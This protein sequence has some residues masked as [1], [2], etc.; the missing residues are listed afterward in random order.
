MPLASIVMSTYNRA[1]LIEEAIESALAQTL[2][3]FELIVVDDGSTDATRDVVMSFSDP[4][5]R[6]IHQENAGLAAGRNTGIGSAR[7]EYIS[8]LDDDDLYLPNK[9]AEQVGFMERH[10]H[11]GWTSSGYETIDSD[12]AV[13]DSERPWVAHPRLEL[14]DWLLSCPTCP[15]AVMASRRWLR[16]IGGFRPDA[17]QTDDWDAWL[18]LAHAGCPMAWVKRILSRYRVHAANMVR[19]AARHSHSAIVMLDRFFSGPGVP[20]ECRDL[21]SEAY[22]RAYLDG[23]VRCYASQQIE[24][25]QERLAKALGLRPEFAT[26]HFP[27]TLAKAIAGLAESSWVADP[28]GYVDTVFNHLPSSLG[29]LGRHRGEALGALYMG[30]V[31]RA[32]PRGEPLAREWLLGA[33]HDPRWLGNRGVWSILV[34]SLTGAQ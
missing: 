6:Y 24:P 33:Y 21:S 29:D 7:S 23:A 18:R 25:A 34:R 14:A 20:Q 17:L 30:R 12:G 13:L 2:G 26:D 4:R 19:D 11:I 32:R 3:D 27:S 8:F 28:L 5:I 22:A 10:P 31:F 15:S 1:H 9:L 16:K